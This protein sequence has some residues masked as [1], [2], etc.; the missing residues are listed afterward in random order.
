MAKSLSNTLTRWHKIAQHIRDKAQEIR[1]KNVAVLNSTQ[2]IDVG[3]FEVR[4]ESLKAATEKALGEQSELYLALVHANFV[5]RKATG[6]AN[7]EMVS[8]LLADMEEA[9]QNAAYFA[10][11]LE[12]ADNALS[13]AEFAALAKKRA[14]TTTGMYDVT[15]TFI[16]G[17]KQ[18]RLA[19]QRENARRSKDSLANRLS[20][21]NA[22]KLV[23]ELDEKVVAFMGL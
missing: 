20:D 15:V 5:I 10:A 22:S 7:V 17:E 19:A 14:G 23:I 2:G 6:R 13:V 9:E 18:E 3:A 21:A 4:Q 11:L 16:S 1:A 8:D 12:T